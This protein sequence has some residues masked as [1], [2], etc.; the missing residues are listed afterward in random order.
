M[1]ATLLVC[2]GNI[3]GGDLSSAA[4]DGFL[5]N[6]YGDQERHD[7]QPGGTEVPA[8]RSLAC[9]KVQPPG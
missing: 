9:R 1:R 4:L 3:I 5:C 2:E 8:H 6:F 7:Q